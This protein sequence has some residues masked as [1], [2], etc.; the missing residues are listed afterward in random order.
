[1]S[2]FAYG[3]NRRCRVSFLAW[4][5]SFVVCGFHRLYIFFL[6]VYSTYCAITVLFIRWDMHSP[7]LCEQTDTLVN[8]WLAG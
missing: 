8:E 4:G 1:M 2:C 5:G 6:F 7:V 3:W